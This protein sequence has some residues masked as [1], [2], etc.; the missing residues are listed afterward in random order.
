M[1]NNVLDASLFDEAVKVCQ[2]AM[3]P[4]QQAE[5]LGRREQASELLEDGV[6]AHELE[7]QVRAGQHP[8]HGTGAERI[9]VLHGDGSTVAETGSMVNQDRRGG[10][11]HPVRPKE[12]VPLV[13]VAVVQE[14]VLQAHV[15]S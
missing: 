9:L 4:L 11:V 14:H 3:S 10:A 12:E 8:F 15:P 5:E 1:Q 13:A 2:D 7:P 6:R